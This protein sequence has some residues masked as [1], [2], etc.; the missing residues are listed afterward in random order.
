MSRDRDYLLVLNAL[1]ELPFSVG[2]KLLKDILRG[3]PHES[4]QKN[5]LDKLSCYG[6][7][8]YGE[9]EVDALIEKVILNHF[10]E[11]RPVPQKKYWKVLQL[12]PK[13][14]QELRHPSLPQKQPGPGI[15]QPTLITPEDREAFKNFDFFLNKYNEEQ[16]KAII[17]TNPHVL[18]IAGA[19]SGKTSVLTKRI[20]FLA[21][22]RS[23]PAKNILAI[24]FTR[25]AKHEM[26][27]RLRTSAFAQGVHI[28]TFN[29]FSEKILQRHNDLAY[30]THVSMISFSEKIKLVGAGL[31]HLGLTR[32][33]AVHQYFTSAQQRL[34]TD[35]ELW[36]GFIN[37]LFSILDHYKNENKPL[38][39]FAQHPHIPVSEKK[40]A[41]MVY[42]L[43]SYIDTTMK[44]LGKRDF[45][46]QVIDCV[47]LFKEHPEII[48]RYEHILI[49]EYQDIN[50]VQIS[51]IDLLQPANLF[52]VGDPRQSIFGWRGSRID[53]I[54]NFTSTYPSAEV[55]SLRINYRSTQP[56]VELGNKAVQHLKLPDLSS[57]TKQNKKDVSLHRFE[58]QAQEFSFI[59]DQIK[60]SENLHHD[61]FV[62]ARTNKLLLELAEQ[63]KKEKIDFVL[64][65]D[66]IKR[67][68]I[69]KH[70]AITLATVHAIKG[71]EAKEVFI[72]GCQSNQFPC[73][74][75]DH[76]VVDLIKNGSYDKEEE[77]R[78]LFY[79]ALSRA[80]EK[81]VF[82]Y[83][84]NHLTR[85]FTNDM[86]Q[87]V[88]AGYNRTLTEHAPTKLTGDLM[89]DLKQWRRELSLKHNTPAYTIL[90]DATLQEIVHQQPLTLD[91][92]ED[93]KGMGPVK[94]QKYG[95]GILDLVQGIK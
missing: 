79:V 49:D 93:I 46:D 73:R 65:S 51:L 34:R 27:K 60:Q 11:I 81:V 29:S 19:G 70:N 9:K 90:N 35:D 75:S 39:H 32:E 71:L 55:I 33:Q 45:A 36:R 72:A 89:L 85:F 8:A 44:T 56:L 78:R 92:L 80:K 66:E 23:V 58:S 3:N 31:K 1:R 83:T 5:R 67:P 94:V 16:K 18:C 7:L 59:I 47:R 10:V 21:Q 20:A 69:D 40:T 24:T 84:G 30:T 37:D 88:G 54:L 77:E 91:E 25:K 26:E 43:C 28:E 53:Y 62:L 13:G 87:L 22:F 41:T 2:K 14:E 42:Q 86:K 38:E 15:E 57:G 52:C 12:T 17:S 4:V 74:T 6:C 76:P 61:I 68:A 95:Q 82:T 63:V 64:R 48:P 50:A